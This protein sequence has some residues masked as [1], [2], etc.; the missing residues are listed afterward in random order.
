MKRIKERKKKRKGG[1]Q[2]KKDGQVTS[3]SVNAGE[4]AGCRPC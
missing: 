4:D 3:A 2:K 1:K